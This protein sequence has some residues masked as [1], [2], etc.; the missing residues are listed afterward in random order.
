MPNSR[1]V[2]SGSGILCNRHGGK[3]VAFCVPIKKNYQR[4]KVWGFANFVSIVLIYH[5]KLGKMKTFMKMQFKFVSFN[6][7]L[8]NHLFK[9]T[10]E[11]CSKKIIA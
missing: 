7:V 3:G 6:Y 8:V 1:L 9:D 2:A 10:K 11:I 5:V 4:D